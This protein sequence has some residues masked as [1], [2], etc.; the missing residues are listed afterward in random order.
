MANA[1]LGRIIN[2]D[3]VQSVV[4][5]LNEVKRR[6]KRKNPLMNM[7][8]VL[9]LNPYLGTAFKMATCRCFRPATY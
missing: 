5:P 8:A 2:S 6:E 3:E 7:A 9:K 1:N 4:K